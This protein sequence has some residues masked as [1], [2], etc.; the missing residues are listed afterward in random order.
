MNYKH[1]LFHIGFFL[2]ILSAS[3]IK[4]YAQVEDIKDASE[5]NSNNSDGDNNGNGSSSGGNFFIDIAFDF[6]SLGF[7]YHTYQLS[8]EKEMPN[9]SSIEVHPT[10][11]YGSGNTIVV[12]PRLRG[13]WGLFSADFR[14]FNLVGGGLYQ[15]FDGQFLLNV[16]NEKEATLRM[17]TGFMHEYSGGKSTYNEHFFGLDIRWNKDASITSNAE[18]RIAK[19]YSTGAT[20][21]LE[22]NLRVNQKIFE[23]GRIVG[24]WTVGGIY[25]RYFNQI[26]VWTGQ[27]G[28]NF[29]LR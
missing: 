16:V 8:R 25:Q 1:F 9:I 5:S 26:N 4:L 6:F 14:Y 23:K 19:D 22:L 13:N 29:A 12:A 17:G 28:L 21:R 2:L 10:I 24:Y 27:T 15:T 3:G 20:P 18:F 11:G 7:Q